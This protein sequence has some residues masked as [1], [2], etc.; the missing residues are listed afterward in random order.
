MYITEQ[1]KRKRLPSVLIDVGEG[2]KARGWRVPF[3][4]EGS[5]ELTD[6]GYEAGLGKSN[7]MGFDLAEVFT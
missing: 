7:M 3:T 1:A 6:I 2:I 5:K 4:I